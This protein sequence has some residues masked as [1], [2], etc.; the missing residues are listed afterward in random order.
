MFL[1]NIKI[2]ELHIAKN[3]KLDGKTTDYINTL[4]ELRSAKFFKP[5]F[6]RR[7]DSSSIYFTRLTRKDK[8]NEYTNK[9]I[10]KFYDKKKH[11]EYK[12]GKISKVI[13]RE[14]LSTIEKADLDGSYYPKDNILDLTNLNLMRVEIAYK[15]SQSLKTIYNSLDG[16]YDIKNLPLATLVN[17]L[18]TRTLYR[19]LDKLFIKELKN[20]IFR[21]VP[22][23]KIK[24]KAKKGNVYTEILPLLNLGAMLNK[25]SD[26]YY[27]KNILITA[28]F[29]GNRNKD[30]ERPIRAKA[31]ILSQGIIKN[32]H[33]NKLYDALFK[34]KY[35]EFDESIVRHYPYCIPEY[36]EDEE[37]D[38]DFN[39]DEFFKDW[40]EEDSEDF[41]L[42]KLES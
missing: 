12:K 29:S 26:L 19:E 39:F 9:K 42:D 10:I 4:A 40:E 23:K 21:F 7:D 31:D 5:I 17:H 25:D 41:I 36:K 33:Y 1:S 24:T 28:G 34:T 2:A 3:I 8:D 20:S 32:P 35:P 16:S 27:I 6:F 11:L 38:S 22:G 18:K 15:S 13:L 30:K 37:Q 14:P